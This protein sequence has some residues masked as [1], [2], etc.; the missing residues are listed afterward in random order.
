LI[1]SLIVM[2]SLS[3]D[4]AEKKGYSKRKALFIGLIPIYGLIYYLRLPIKKYGMTQRSVKLCYRP[5]KI[6]SKF[7]IYFELLFVATLVLIPVIYIIGASLSPTS[8]LPNTIWPKKI[9]WK[10]Y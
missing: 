8:S 3:V 1:T 4:I 6:I 9:T 7:F 5:K 2:Q 10:N